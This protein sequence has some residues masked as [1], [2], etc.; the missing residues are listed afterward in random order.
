ML[1][2][3]VQDE[4]TLNDR[5]GDYSY[6][7]NLVMEDYSNYFKASDYLQTRYDFCL[8]AIYSCLSKVNNLDNRLMA[9]RE[10]AKFLDNLKKKTGLVMKIVSKEKLYVR[11]IPKIKIKR[12]IVKTGLYY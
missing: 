3:K 11:E 9:Y 7:F 5:S 6:M 10:L 8:Q 1:V 12:S 4:N 2:Y